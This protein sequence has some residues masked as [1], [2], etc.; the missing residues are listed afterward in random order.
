MGTRARVRGY[1]ERRL[2]PLPVPLGKKRPVVKGWEKMRVTPENVD[3]HFTDDQ[4]IGILNGKPSDGLV[5][6][7]CDTPEA[8]ALA[9]EFLPPTDCIFGRDSKPRSHFEYRTAEPLKTMQFEV[10]EPAGNGKD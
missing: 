10:T 9:G 8:V 7:D 4:N 3:D 2:A 1:L 6:V 5:D